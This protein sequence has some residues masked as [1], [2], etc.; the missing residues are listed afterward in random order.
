MCAQNKYLLLLKAFILA[1]PLP[2]IAIQAGW[3]LAEVGRQ[4]W[5]VYDMMRAVIIK[6]IFL[7]IHMVRYD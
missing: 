4:P 2:Y 6:R 3:V 5:I 1:I 7:C